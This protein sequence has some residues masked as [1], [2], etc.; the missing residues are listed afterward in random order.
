M[1]IGVI[2]PGGSTIIPPPGWGAVEILIHDSVTCLRKLGHEVEIINLPNTNDMIR[3]VNSKDFDIV[4]IQYDDR[5]DM[6]PFIKCRN[7]VQST[8]YAYLEQPD[9]WYYP[10]SP[11]AGWRSIFRNIISSRA[12]IAPCS[13]G[14]AA[15]Y[16]AAGVPESRIHTIKNGVRNE[17]FRFTISPIFPERSLYLAKIDYRKRQHLFKDIDNLYFAGHIDSSSSFPAGHIRHLGEWK[18]ET[19]YSDLT[20]YANLVLLSDGEN[21]PLVCL[22]ALSAGLGLVLSECSTANLDL[23]L[24]FIDVIP[25]EKINDA[26]YITNVLTKNREVSCKM[27]KDIREYSLDFSWKKVVHDLY[28]PTYKSIIGL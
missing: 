1:K 10:H 6:I 21:H 20:N 23:S 7:I 12:H 15:V 18:K 24:P 11:Q 26:A 14:I 3:A 28:I 9:V 5:C 2:G 17:L 4:H 22:E 19:L 27:R 13:P 16:R 8:H 25:E